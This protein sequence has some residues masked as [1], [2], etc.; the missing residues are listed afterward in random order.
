MDKCEKCGKPATIL[1]TDVIDGKQIEKSLCES[2][3]ASEGMTV[4]SKMSL[5]QLLEEFVLHTSAGQ[6]TPSWPA[7]SAG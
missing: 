7:T 6:E 4:K 3:A 5:S 2:C 1:L